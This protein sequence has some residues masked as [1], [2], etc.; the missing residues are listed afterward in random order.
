[1]NN[2]GK[3]DKKKYGFEDAR[4]THQSKY[5][6]V[7][8]IRDFKSNSTFDKYHYIFKDN[9]P[10]GVPKLKIEDFFVNPESAKDSIQ[11]IRESTEQPETYHK[12]KPNK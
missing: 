8:R 2:D 3:I 12:M 11:R 10:E 7:K 4:V 5:G 1:M 9:M 6:D